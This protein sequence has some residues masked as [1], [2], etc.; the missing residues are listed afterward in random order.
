MELQDKDNLIAQTYTQHKIES[1]FLKNE[2]N[3]AHLQS[4]DLKS[5]LKKR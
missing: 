2:I 3:D 4:A 1:E 5:K